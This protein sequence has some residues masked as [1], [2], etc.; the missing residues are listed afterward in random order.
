M[1]HVSRFLN[2]LTIGFLF[3]YVLCFTI[4]NLFSIVFGFT[5]SNSL[6]FCGIFCLSESCGFRIGFCLSES[7]GFATC[8]ILFLPIISGS[9]SIILI[10]CLFYK[11]II[12]SRRG[13]VESR[14]PVSLCVCSSNNILPTLFYVSC[15]CFGLCTTFP[16]T[17]SKLFCTTLFHSDSGI[18]CLCTS[19]SSAF[20]GGISTTL[21]DCFSTS[22]TTTIS[23]GI[24]SGIR[25]AMGCATRTI[26][27]TCLIPVI[28]FN[29][30]VLILGCGI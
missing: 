25:T 1:C 23:S 14:Y 19:L 22:I 28:V 30:V 11:S 3:G 6:F 17:D 12:Q 7:C 4:S 16:L 13:R 20:C 29:G 26:F 2:C 24:R 10:S 8:T 18:I 9:G 21:H 15:S 5:K 27:A